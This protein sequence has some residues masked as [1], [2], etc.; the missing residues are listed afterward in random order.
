MQLI[1]ESV[2]L[3]GTVEPRRRS[4]VA[5]EIDGLV[6]RH[7]V[8]EG[9]EVKRGALLVKL[10]TDTLELELQE[11]EAAHREARALHEQA[12]QQLTRTNTLYE[13]G[14]ATLKQLQDEQANEQAR[15]EKL[16]QLA[17]NIAKVN[18]RIA[19]SRIT[20][21]FNGIVVKKFT[22]V[23]QWLKQGESAVEIVDV[24]H[25]RVEVP[26]P[27]RLIGHLTIG[28]RIQVSFDALPD[29]VIDGNILSIIGQADE[30]SRTF[31]VKID[32]ENLNRQIHSGMTARVMLVVGQPVEKKTVPKDAL[33]IRGDG[34]L[35]FVVTPGEQG[36][37]V[38]P[39]PVKTGVMTGGRVEIEGSVEVGQQV[40]IRGNERLRPGQPVQVTE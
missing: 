23:G 2:T 4:L 10:K 33:V 30:R 17:T 37:T 3:V 12:R 18:D 7:P 26:V 36:S 8:D 32:L 9:D 20:A 28:D 6:D 24:D 19:K 25:I 15:G 13:E 40:V 14:L 35:V 39:V 29:V 34:Y 27:E 22:E 5:S 11:A 21:P 38:A 16:S 31:P 1:A